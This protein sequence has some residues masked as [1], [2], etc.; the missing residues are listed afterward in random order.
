MS[1]VYSLND[2]IRELDEQT[3]MPFSKHVM[4]SACFA[5]EAKVQGASGRALGGGW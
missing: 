2:H 3:R 5:F 1:A 4:K